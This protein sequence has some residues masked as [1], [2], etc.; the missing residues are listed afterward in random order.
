MSQKER[1]LPLSPFLVAVQNIDALVETGED[2]LGC[3][4]KGA[5]GL[6]YCGILPYLYCTTYI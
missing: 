2:L 3:E 4:E 1:H 6:N 5:C